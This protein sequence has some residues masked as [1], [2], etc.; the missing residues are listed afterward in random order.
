MFV[1]G[2][3]LTRVSQYATSRT[4]S[5]NAREREKKVTPPLPS[6]YSLPRVAFYICACAGDRKSR[7]RS[8]ILYKEKWEIN[9]HAHTV[10]THQVKG[11]DGK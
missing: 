6:L 2:A 4:S 8:L 7:L 10:H 3:E 11:F 5:S 9:F 1:V